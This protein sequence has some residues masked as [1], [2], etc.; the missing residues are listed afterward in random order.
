[1]IKYM[2]ELVGLAGGMNGD[3]AQLPDEIKQQV[4]ST[5]QEAGWLD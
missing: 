1:M 4:K 5:L 2:Q 3:G